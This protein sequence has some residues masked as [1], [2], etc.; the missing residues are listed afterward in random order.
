VVE[1]EGANFVE[2]GRAKIDYAYEYENTIDSSNLVLNNADSRFNLV[3]PLGDHLLAEKGVVGVS[4]YGNDSQFQADYDEGELDLS[5]CSNM[6]RFQYGA[7]LSDYLDVGVGVS[8]YR[9]PSIGPDRN[10]GQS[11]EIKITPS[12]NLAIEFQSLAEYPAAG[13]LDRQRINLS[14][15]YEI[16]KK[17]EFHG[18]LGKGRSGQDARFYEDGSEIAYLHADRDNLFG[19]V[20][21]AWQ[22]PALDIAL[23]FSRSVSDFS[24]RGKIF[25]ENSP[26][27]ISNVDDVEQSYDLAASLVMNG[28]HLGLKRA[29]SDRLSLKTDLRYFALLVEGDAN[30]WNGWFFGAVKDLQGNYPSPI[31]RV[32]FVEA[33]LGFK[34]ALQEELEFNYTFKQLIPVAVDRVEE[35]VGGEAGDYVSDSSPASGGNT[36]MVSLTCYF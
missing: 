34:Y 4:V 26:D 25:A 35:E 24:S 20:G 28:C 30:I 22:L 32:D 23:D 36:Q 8:Q 5:S 9:D 31:R 10:L 21:L 2:A 1:W 18:L 29:L 3:L 19:K 14:A 6:V 11:Y 16:S 7:R 15:C 33:G 12:Q 13:M 17:V 27:M